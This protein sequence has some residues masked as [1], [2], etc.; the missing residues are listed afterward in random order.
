MVFNFIGNTFFDFEN[1]VRHLNEIRN[2][3]NSGLD[4]AFGIQF[5]FWQKHALVKSKTKTKKKRI[6]R[7]EKENITVMIMIGVYRKPG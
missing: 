4:F 7:G 5:G 2:L 3:A 6:L 1:R